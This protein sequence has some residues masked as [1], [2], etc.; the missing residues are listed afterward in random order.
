MRAI[1]LAGGQN[2]GLGPITLDIPTPAL[3][4]AGRPLLTRTLDYLERQGMTDA[5]VSCYRWPHLVERVVD[6][7]SGTMPVTTALESPP[8]GSGNLLRQIVSPEEGS[9][10]VVM[11]DIL[12]DLDLRAAIEL[13]R[14]RG[15][16]ATVVVADADVPC[17]YGEVATDRGDAVV[18]IGSEHLVRR[19]GK[20][21]ANSGIYVLEAQALMQVPMDR[22]F[23]LAGDLLPLLVEKEMPV[24]AARGQGYWRTISSIEQ[25]RAANVDVLER[26]V[27]GQ[28]PHGEEVEPGVWK[29]AG[30]RIDRTAIVHPPVLVGSGCRVE[31]DAVIGPDTV[32]GEGVQLRRGASAIRTVVLPRSKVGLATRLE[33]AVVRGSVLARATRSEPTYVDDPQML[34]TLVPMDLQLAAK[35]LVDRAVAS[36]ALILILPFLL[37]VAL[38]IKLDSPGPVLYSQLRVGQ[39]RRTTSGQYQ[40]KVFELVKFRTM[41]QDADARLKE[42]LGQNEYGRAPFVKIKNDPRIT[43]VGRLLRATSVDELPQLINVVKGDMGLVGNRPL[44]LYEAERLSDEWQRIRFSAPAGITGLWQI[45]GRSDL[46]AEERIVLDN[47]YALTHSFWSDVKILL[48]TIPALLARRGAR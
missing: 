47:Y 2:D 41:Y 38:L 15:A 3:P 33:D 48:V 4:I 20:R 1:V 22:S 32:L 36:L 46:S 34:E 37:L 23:D 35:S 26:K 25:Y 31:R 45:S 27:G 43:R 12:A 18:M 14:E 11:G 24:V 7:Y 8:F 5:V 21:Q 28:L 40:G 19:E 17:P 42:V 39:G 44:P 13:H 9:F 16:L 29:A 30:A 6:E 10:V